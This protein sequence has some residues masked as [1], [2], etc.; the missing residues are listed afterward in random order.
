MINIGTFAQDAVTIT[1][2][3][4]VD[5]VVSRIP[6]C[7]SDV[8]EYSI[9]TI[10][11]G[12][13]ISI[14]D[15]N[16]TGF[17]LLAVP[18]IAILANTYTIV[19]TCTP[20]GQDSV[21]Y[22][23]SL[24]R[25]DRNEYS[26]ILE[27]NAN[28]N[29]SI[30]EN[31]PLHSVVIDIN[32]TDSDIG[33]FGNVTYSIIDGNIGNAFAIDSSTGELTVINTLNYEM[34]DSYE[35]TIQARNL[36]DLFSNVQQFVNAYV[37]IH[38]TAI[39]LFN[40]SQYTVS[41][42]E[43]GTS[44]SGEVFPRPSPGFLT[45][46][47][48]DADT[49]SEI[50]TYSLV[51]ADN[52]VFA[53]NS[54]TGELRVISNLD[55]DNPDT[56]S[57]EFEAACTDG[58][59]TD[60][61]L[62]QITVD[63]VN[64]HVPVATITAEPGI[65]T[66]QD[67]IFY[68]RDETNFPVGR[69]LLSSQQ[70]N[71]SIGRVT[72]YD[73]DL[74]EDGQITFTLVPPPLNYLGQ[75][76]F[77]INSQTGDLMVINAIN[78]DDDRELAKSFSMRIGVFDTSRVFDTS[79]QRLFLTVTP[80]A[81]ELPMFSQATYFEFKSEATAIGSHLL[82]A[83]CT[84]HDYIY[85]AFSYI[86]FLSASE[87]VMSHISLNNQT[88]GIF[89]TN[90]LDYEMEQ[91]I[92]FTLICYDNVGLNDT[93]EITISIVP[94]N[95]KVPYF[96]SDMY[97]FP[98]SL[99]TPSNFFQVGEVIAYDDDLGY[100]SNLTYSMEQDY[101]LISPSTGVIFLVESI[102]NVKNAT[103][104]YIVTVNDDDNLHTVTTTVIFN[105]TEGNYEAP[106]F[107]TSYPLIEINELEPIGSPLVTLFCNDTE[108]GDNGRVSYSI[109]AGNVASSFRVDSTT[110]VISVASSLIL[111]QNTS[112]ASYLL[113][114][115][116][117]DHGT[118]SLSD[119][120]IVRI[121]VSL[122]STLAPDI[123][124]DTIISFVDEDANLNHLVV[125]ISAIF[126]ED[127]QLNFFFQNESIANAFRV[128]SS[129]TEGD[130]LVNSVLNREA[131][132]S[133]TM[134]VVAEVAN[135]PERND[136]AA[137][138]IYLRDVNDN[139]PQCGISSDT[140]Q[141]QET[142]AKDS[143][144]L[145]LNCSD[146]DFGQNANLT[147]SFLNDYGIFAINSGGM[148]YLSDH[149]NATNSTT[150]YLVITVSDQGFSPRSTTLTIIVN[151]IALNNF[152]PSF[153]NLPRTLVISE[154][155]P[156]FQL[157]LFTV[158]ATDN[159]KGRFGIV[160]YA[161]VGQSGLP[162][163]LVP[164]TGELY[165]N[166]KLDYYALNQ[167]NLNISAS[168]GVYTVHSTLI[169]NV[170]DSNEY[171]PV[172]SSSLITR[173]IVE[174]IEPT[175]IPL[176][177][178]DSDKGPN[179]D[180]VYNI[181]SGNTN[182]DF[183]VTSTGSVR[184]NNPLDY[185]STQSYQLQIQVADS[186]NPPRSITV[187]VRVTVSPKNEFDPII[188]NGP[189]SVSVVENTNIGY[190]VFS[191][192]ATDDDAGDDGIL[193][194]NLLPEQTAFGIT[195]QG[196]LLVTGLIDREVRSQ[197]S[198]TITVNDEGTMRST[199]S[200]SAVINVLDVDDSPPQ[201]NQSLYVNSVPDD[202]A[203]IGSTI[204]STR[205]ID[206]DSGD[207]ARHTYSILSSTYSS[208]F[209]INDDGD[210][211][212][213]SVLPVSNIY[214]LTVQ[215]AG[216][217][218]PNLTDTAV[219]SITIMIDSN[220]TFDNSAYT[221]TL[222]E[223]TSPVHTFLTVNA[224]S[225]T[226]TSLS[227]SLLDTFSLFQIG[228][229]SGELALTGF[230]DYEMQ[231]SYLLIVEATDNG[232]PP[233]TGQ[234]TVN[235]FVENTNDA[236]PTF[237]S[238]TTNIAITEQQQYSLPI[239]QY[240][241]TD[242]DSGVYGDITYS[243]VSGNVNDA[244]GIDATGGQ[245]QLKKVLN[246]EDIQSTSLQIRCADGGSP[247]Q[248]QTVIVSVTVQA[249]NE[250]APQF[251]ADIISLTVDESL[252]VPT[253]ITVNNELQ[254]TDSDLTPHNKV[255]YSITAG[256][257]DQHFAVSS[258]SSDLTL[259][260]SLDFEQVQSFT[261]TVQADDSGGVADPGYTVLNST[262]QVLITVTDAND[263]TPSFP[264]NIYVGSISESALAGDYV[265]MSPLNC[266]DADS[267]QNGQ[268]VLTIVSGNTGYTFVA[269][270]NGRIS[271]NNTLD[272]ESES[273]YYLTVRCSD[274]GS[275]PRYVD[276]MV[277]I[278]INDVSE[279]GP[280]FQ[281]SSYEFTISE[282]AIPGTVVGTV[283]AVDQDTGSAGEITYQLSNSSDV[284]FGINPTNGEIFVLVPLDY[285]TGPSTYDLRIRAYDFVNQSDTTVVAI[286]IIN[287]DESVPVLSGSNYFGRLRESSPPGSSVSL[288]TSLTCS[289]ADDAADD[290]S[291]V[292]SLATDMGQPVES[293]FEFNIHETTG[294]IT[295]LFILD[296]EVNSRY[297]FTIVCTDS[298]GNS[299]SAG[300][301]VDLLPYNDFAPVFS[302]TP[303]SITLSEGINL[304]SNI[305]TVVATDEDEKSYQ[306]ITFG[307]EPSSNT[308]SRFTIDPTSGVVTNIQD[309]DYEQSTEYYLNVTATNIIP[310]SDMSGSPSLSSY[311]TLYINVT[312]INDN[313]PVLTPPAA[314]ALIT[315]ED[316]PGTFVIRVTCSDADSGSFGNTTIGLS[317][318][319][320]NKFTL[321]SNGTVI[322]AANITSDLI[323]TIN[324]SDMG[325]P[326][327]TTTAEIT[328]SST[329]TNDYP[330][331]FTRAD[332][333]RLFIP[334]NFTVGDTF[335][336]ITATDDDGTLTA[337]GILTYTIVFLSGDNHFSLDSSTGCLQLVAA[338]DYDD[339]SLY[340]YRVR[341]EDGGVPRKTATVTLIINIIDVEFD[342]PEFT[343]PAVSRE[344]SEGTA[345]GAIVTQNAVCMDR[346]D[347]DIITYSIVGG[348]EDN[349]F[350]INSTRGTITL[351]NTLDYE[352]TI[353]HSLAVR[354]TDNTGLYDEINVTVTVTPVNE[355][356]PFIISKLVQINEQSTIGT[357]ITIIDYT[358]MDAGIDGQVSFEIITSDADPQPRNDQLFTIS[359]H[360]LLVNDVLDRE[361]KDRYDIYLRVTDLAT[362]SRSSFDYVNVSLIDINDK[363]PSPDQAI[364]TS[365]INENT[366]I[367]F[368]VL[369]IHCNDSDIGINALVEYSIES[370]SLFSVNTTNGV[371]SVTS[372]LRFRSQD[373]ISL[374]ATCSDQ[375]MPTLSTTVP[376]TISI[377]S[378]NNHAPIFIQAPP[379]I[380]LSE[381]TTLLV[382][383]ITV[384]ATDADVGLNGR[385][386]YSLIDDYDNQFFINH[387]TGNISLLLPLDYESVT[388]YTL[389]VQA[390]DGSDDSLHMN[391]MNTT[392]NVIIHVTGINEY[393]PI[394]TQ[395]VYSSYIN[396]TSQGEVL[397]LSCT[398]TD[399]GVDGMLTYSVQ[400]SLYSSLFDINSNGG[401]I[402]VSPISPNASITAYEVTVIVAD[403][404][405][406][407]KETEIQVNLIY[408]FA[409]LHSPVFTRDSYMFTVSESTP[410]GNVVYTITATDD[411]P[412]IQ[413]EIQYT[414]TNTD[415]FRV[416]PTT[417]DIFVAQ[418]LN[419]ED[420]STIEFQLIAS[421]S[422][423]V[424][425]R[426][427][428]TAINVTIGDEN[429]NT[430]QCEAYFYT[431]T[432]GSSLS[433]GET[434]FNIG[435]KCTDSDGPLHS[436]LSYQVQPSNTFGITST[437]S[438]IVNGT[439]TPYT[440]TSLTVT[441]S[442]N[443]NRFTML[444]FSVQ[445]TFTN[446][447]PPMFLQ[448]Q[449]NFTVQEDT[450]LLASIGQVSANDSDSSSSQLQYSLA[451]TNI[452]SF[453]IDPDTGN[454]ILVS[455]IDYETT[456]NYTI[457]VRVVDGGSHD[458]SN[459]LMDTAQVTITVI[460][461]NDNS[462]LFDN[463]GI[464][465]STVN[466]TTP[467]GSLV[468][469]IQCTDNDLPSFGNPVI[470]GMN[471][472][473]IPFNLSSQVGGSVNVQVS[474]DLTTLV[475]S[476]S[477]VLNITCTDQGNRV[478]Q[479]QV[480]LFVPE[481]GAPLFN[482]TSYEW[483]IA[484]NS[485]VGITFTGLNVISQD[486]SDLSYSIT[487]GNSNGTF[488][489]NPTTGIISLA[490]SLDYEE[491][492][493]YGLIIRSTDG[494]NRNSSTLLLVNV[495][496]I[497][498]QLPL[499]S[500]TASLMVEQYRS[501]GYPIG[502][503]SCVDS[504]SHS[505]LLNYSFVPSATRFTIDNSGI[506]YVNESLDE[507]PVYVLPV[508]CYDITQ[509]DVVSKGIVTVEVVF[510]NLHSPVFDYQSYHVSTP[511]NTPLQ[512]PLATV[513]ATD[514]DIGSNGNIQY[515]II[516]GNPDKFYINAQTGVIHLLTSLDREI[517]STY[518]LTVKATDGG[519]INSNDTDR[520]TATTNVT[521]TVLDINDN[522]PVLNQPSYVK[523]IYTN[524]SLLASVLQ[525]Q[526]SDSD[527][528]EN[529]T[530]SFS[531]EQDD[532][533]FSVSSNGTIIMTSTQSSEAIHNFYVRCTD[534]SI[535]PLSSSSLVTIVV[536]KVDFASPVF[537]FSSYSQ[538]VPEN[539]ELLDPFLTVYANTSD[540][541]S[542]V[543]SISTGND[544]NNFYI[545][546]S[547]GALSVINKLNYN[548]RNL[549]TL[550]I[551][552][553]TG[554][555][556]Q[557][558]GYTT[559][560]ISI[561]D[562]NDHT[563]TFV[564][565]SFYVATI[566]EAEPSLTPV[567]QVNCTD[568]DPTDIL[569][570]SIASSTP[571]QGINYFNIT[572]EGLVITTT[573]LDYESVTLFS[574]TVHCS[575]G[576]ATPVEAIVQVTVGS[577]NEFRP[578]F[579]LNKYTFTV[580][581]T[582]SVGAHLGN[583]SASDNDTGI[584][585][586]FSYILVDPDNSS[587]I[588]VD[589][590]TGAVIV[591]S[592]LDYETTTFYNL[593][594][595][596]RDYGGSETYVPV[597]ITVLNIQDVD[598]VLTPA[599]SVYD[600]R[601]LSTSPV[602]FF[603]ES[604][605][606]ID[607]D[608]GNTFISISSG[609][610]Q[611]YL[612]LNSFNQIVYNGTSGS[613]SSDI[614][615][616]LILQCVDESNTVTTASLAVVIGHPD[617][618]AP[619]FN[620]SLYMQSVFEN[621]TNGTQVLTVYA[622]GNVNHTL[623]YSLAG[624]LAGFPFSIN[625]SSGVV[626]VSGS[627][628]Y[629]STE[630]YSFPVQATDLNDSTIALTIVTIDIIDVNDN[631]P[632][633]LPQSIS[634]LLQ[635]SSPTDTSYAKFTCTDQDD[636]SN[637]IISY[638]I[639]SGSPFTITP[640]GHI[641]LESSLDYESFQEYNLTIVCNDGGAPS[642]TDTSV[643]LVRVTGVNEYSPQFSM[644]SYN[645]TISERTTLST[646]VGSVS[647]VDSD[648]GTNGDFIF[649]DYGGSGS[650]FFAIDSSSGNIS[651]KNFLNASNDEQLT[652][653]V[654]AIDN[655]PPSPLLSVVSVTFTVE[656]VNDYPYFTAPSYIVSVRTDTVSIG[657]TLTTVTCYDYDN[658]P[659]GRVSLAIVSNLS[660]DNITLSDNSTGQG[661]I[662]SD[663]ILGHSLMQGS[664]E[665]IIQ[666]TDMGQ[667]RL[668]R[669]IS[670]VLI[671]EGANSA[672]H[673]GFEL[674]GLSIN[675]DTEVGTTLLSVNATDAES[676]AVVYSLSGGTGLGTFGINPS[677]GDITLLLSLDYET[678]DNYILMVTASDTDSHNPMSST[679]TISIVIANVNDHPPLLLPSTF[680]TILAEG[681]YTD[682]N[683]Q[684]L[685]YTCTDA[686]GG[687]TFISISPS[688][689]LS[690]DDS[691]QVT[692]NGTID[693]EVA[694]VVTA[695][696]TCVDSTIAGADSTLSSLATLS[697][698]VSPVNF[699]DPIIT[700]PDTFN[701]S[702]GS[703]V[704][705]T[706]AV[707]SAFDPDLRGT[708][709]YQT[710]SHSSIAS[711][712]SNTGQLVLL[713]S[714]DR[715]NIDMYEF[716]IIVSDNDN[717]QSVIPK[718]TSATVTL[719]ITDIN[720][721]APVCITTLQTIPLLAGQYNDS[722]S[723]FNASCSD[724]DI[725]LNGQIRYS[726]IDSTLP[727]EGTFSLDPN[728]GMLVFTGTITKSSSGSIIGL[729]AS[730]MGTDTPS[731]PVLIQLI[732]NIF[733]GNEPQFDPSLFNITIPENYPSTVPVLNGS[734][735][736][737]S[738]L[739]VDGAS[740]TFR[741]ITNTTDFVLDSS[742]GDV[743][744]LAASELDYDQGQQRYSL[745]IQATVGTELTEAI[746][747]VNLA[748]YNDNPPVFTQA[749]YNGTVMENTPSGQNVLTV[750][751]T[752]ID[753]GNNS[754]VRYSILI[755]NS[756]F[757]IDPVSGVVTTLTQFDREVIPS[758]SLF[759]QATD[760]GNPAMS[761][762]V[763]VT[764]Y[765]GDE[766]DNS[767]MFQNSLYNF[768]IS[769]LARK[770]DI[771]HTFNA[772]DPDIT[773]S[774][775]YSLV[776]T[777][778]SSV[779]DFLQ[780][781]DFTGVLS[782]KNDI[783][784]NHE[785][786]YSFKIT[787]NDEIETAEADVVLQI[788]TLSQTN[789]SFEENVPGQTYSV[790]NFLRL[791]SNLS[792][793]TVYTI[794]SGDE[795]GQFDV[796]DNGILT[797]IE[798]LDRENISSYTLEISAMDNTTNQNSIL[799]LGITVADK[800]DN[801]PEFNSS[802]YEISILEGHY[803]T[804][805]VI[806]GVYATDI[807][808]PN[809]GNSRIEY[810]LVVKPMSPSFDIRIHPVSGLLTVS[811]TL[812]REAVSAG[813]YSLTV[814][815]EDN[816]EPTP[817]YGFATVILHLIDINDNTPRFEII[818]VMSFVIHYVI[819]V[820]IGSRPEYMFALRTIS[821]L[822]TVQF[823]SFNFFDPDI[824]DNV[825]ASLTNATNMTLY[826]T[827]SPTY[828][829]STGDITSDLNNTQFV[830]SLSDG[831]N[832]VSR[833]VTVMVIDVPPSSTIIA[834]STSSAIAS[835][836]M[837]SSV[838]LTVTPSPTGVL[839][840]V[841]TPIG[842]ATLIVGTV[843]FFALVLCVFCVICFCYQSYQRKKDTAQ[844]YSSYIYIV[845]K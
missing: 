195:N 318:P 699:F 845:Y 351:A 267:G 697:I 164:N 320:A 475:G 629:E 738:L 751:A 469:S 556:I 239:G 299:V 493:T 413:G 8:P 405:N 568:L 593:S 134:T 613:F 667:P 425:P 437:G 424:S 422:D 814:L 583:V 514:A 300:I 578:V 269:L 795:L 306:T 467:I 386:T 117:T 627:L 525:T 65:V 131:V 614:V 112:L 534:E 339:N 486:G 119:N 779:N 222:P 193:A 379:N 171:S 322:T 333:V 206:P 774:I 791:S 212:I 771:L 82:T 732:L 368:E 5:Y 575:D 648:D 500:P 763:T 490:K 669:N 36:V 47:C 690:L 114:V 760:L 162:F 432:I 463:D 34:R 741:F 288:T 607:G 378:V 21:G 709:S 7:G 12:V 571:S 324:C 75:P 681:D 302:N 125:T 152:A 310:V 660:N 259:I 253:L 642:L 264:K 503:V 49:P 547:T 390:I 823:D 273:S 477:Y 428:S 684:N 204:V 682:Y 86:D 410:V 376:V 628:N 352:T 289:D 651:V 596:A 612:A 332:P 409:N 69:V 407:Q 734:V 380:S 116:C 238:A 442:D 321:L 623:E 144:L 108:E 272:F 616:S 626:T 497:N 66:F 163:I 824:S 624:Q 22:Q 363:A 634:L 501:S 45:V 680:T 700:S 16:S 512:S 456:V 672:P 615:V 323:L 315:V 411:D 796:I 544:N 683:I 268:T 342:P 367:G 742:T 804:T 349:V 434:I 190:T 76:Y 722:L 580:N 564:P 71:D 421:D 631:P 476:N 611:G 754:V 10:E 6:N 210:I 329:S 364:Y 292:Y 427:T 398:D 220:I 40:S 389:Q 391:R 707:I 713:T 129:G 802:Q 524:H 388:M 88:G 678:T 440:S 551:Q 416:N 285:E 532:G 638:S 237:T 236:V 406:P 766:N 218:N 739:N 177:C 803:S 28:L 233:N 817:L 620:A 371:V 276:V 597:E 605:T 563:S 840:F 347:D 459:V 491:T 830:L 167:Y 658:G 234:V 229:T 53:I 396:E 397:R 522:S 120:T 341:A 260:K 602:G 758:Y 608:N 182:N 461:V 345:M 662:S 126:Y 166:S 181:I 838:V 242:A 192:N 644:D 841:E 369:T 691:G 721:N 813:S 439:L 641:R 523:T 601:V 747:Q 250:H 460:N 24:T 686:D 98:V 785:L 186:G 25:I 782:L 436:I 359:G 4:P 510:V 319:N 529:G 55:Y 140:L 224:T 767:P 254:A 202:Q 441:V 41:V 174:N 495:I 516:G 482:S 632:V 415:M 19:A 286:T 674:Y 278:N 243:I 355:F 106:M 147:Y 201:F 746:L 58:I 15:T 655:G 539:Q 294:V 331:V 790:L 776:T 630:S 275:S 670:V 262:T 245:L 418:E 726:I 387:M 679:V 668:S 450:N 820:P 377:T 473:S 478:T 454:V 101:F 366:S 772:I 54:T 799:L 753:S 550:T 749:Q 188:H 64:E 574:L 151:I 104:E 481:L 107:T 358:D 62:I 506:I 46:H 230:L 764:V 844:R 178:S 23:V 663:L 73:R 444:T 185:E 74:G 793:D 394:C 290:I 99:T 711:L 706:I 561:D 640:N 232:V 618:T 32:A 303:Y 577:V 716:V 42:P 343:V 392:L 184:P 528:S 708:V 33:D 727:S 317:G 502:T 765:I 757:R 109:I 295:S 696:I 227:Y 610:S 835:S 650:S 468:L 39:P 588:F 205:C 327:R 717:I 798:P 133:Y 29:Q 800:N 806:G 807:D 572:T 325:S 393:T 694:T 594:V 659:N 84:D 128:F 698:T 685:L 472:P 833:D 132:S 492:T 443:G 311:T 100:G 737:N 14:V 274:Q 346:D 249:V 130:V 281:N 520:K 360:T 773:G 812:D 438:I 595:I 592:I 383:F 255:W 216:V 646:V 818:Q 219:V 692:F 356:T 211:Q 825:E 843:L 68:A 43:T 412:G 768:V 30:P 457:T 431:V 402:V 816:G 748:D 508:V 541:I 489:I 822:A 842:I 435:D 256:N 279:F 621:A 17:I 693:Y 426:N 348:N 494:S 688:P 280:V 228:T 353:L 570:Y 81:D 775:I 499:V 217:L 637:G 200:V 484:E 102:R 810:E 836:T 26:P 552:A 429:D 695:T 643:L 453:F 731:T 11:P 168:D 385:I 240:T 449:Y 35:I 549:Y 277:I 372:D 44:L 780:L 150:F 654:A 115:R 142:T 733:T 554:G 719:L 52:D 338:L 542:V 548:E 488:Y 584:D 553:S 78:I 687:S 146:T 729:L 172:C 246:Y 600:G 382:P 60:T 244:F 521:V 61:T 587:A 257:E 581:E 598:P 576:R 179:G 63:P 573:E 465:G 778:D 362:F 507:T 89:L 567:V 448:S 420:G 770:G 834:P 723:L 265:D 827:S 455:P 270:S 797:N 599:I 70:H 94:V 653:A 666:C 344:M 365:T 161:L 271:V 471:T 330:P 743:F 258:S 837:R 480:Y 121:Q 328:V 404:G 97:I 750:S 231:Q 199:S 498:D 511:E 298:A 543:Y 135:E 788:A 48:T 400:N 103:L 787:A 423:P 504:D 157:P 326:P 513:H 569:T 314:S 761:S 148:L 79:D 805:T 297:S 755:G 308:G 829:I 395:P 635:E 72:G 815:A 87:F 540:D 223:N 169:V 470:S 735:L 92:D 701:V 558:S 313:N 590:T 652:L 645:F 340:T 139:S 141:I 671:V 361:V 677:T 91:S 828:L 57:Y 526:C 781:N 537:E 350:A 808:Q 533:D 375:G 37:T 316:P 118:P 198:F 591:S 123:S 617:S 656:D 535:T 215:C 251:S 609:N 487:D 777:D 414:V 625:R 562:V 373:V 287:I 451:S 446:V 724:D 1:Q 137:L 248:F 789:I 67:V 519:I 744:L 3:A 207:N 9:I 336:C 357:P 714:L 725:G 649:M 196:H 809:T 221:H 283:M 783:P 158:H 187:T 585:G 515:S 51:G 124:N 175:N 93:A 559:V 301:T 702:E 718:T 113:E 657:D 381:N 703:N 560:N 18:G 247:S 154:A 636:S 419:W 606:C 208:Y 127:S 676:G 720:D 90:G 675:E 664:H 801:P 149:L 479:G 546:P 296:L 740:V 705:D 59:S 458:G 235:V 165:L 266:T 176:G 839:N 518:T 811:G 496:D 153:T 759:V 730:D 831:V 408:S 832:K 589:P 712:N 173:V 622:F 545:D 145:N 80:A 401:V 505:T 452:T 474:Q 282:T 762:S 85:G 464:Y 756:N 557:Y 536:V 399:N 225:V 821:S 384:T 334:E 110:G 579:A 138:F 183:T 335:D 582:V 312:D 633:L 604:Y 194:Y 736:M 433:I 38:I 136:S 403:Q 370:N 647:A 786:L 95:D 603:I 794:T 291:T 710:D 530:V 226:G 203:Y 170:T 83:N 214:S 565:T 673:F 704:G 445:V 619:V 555:F 769:D 77:Q 261:L 155:T 105:I 417:G 2:N 252:I 31:F 143:I 305:F 538:M 447:Q 20:S 111:P 517:V 156:V 527:L 337:D 284:P 462:P 50:I 309:I 241:C 197:Y 466:K 293:G 56:Q 586:Q 122:A 189:F 96:T 13:P 374:E 307:I 483:S 191:V 792:S 715:E 263:N 304:N 665:L 485:E 639:Q 784:Q 354:C 826:N 689:P 566:D 509:P 819:G 209:L 752:D 159:D 728:F 745:G 27:H 160:R 661:S 213:S 531:I 180:L 430:P